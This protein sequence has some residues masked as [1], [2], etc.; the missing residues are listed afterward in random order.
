MPRASW[1]L[2]L[3]MELLVKN[4]IIIAAV[5][6]GAVASGVAH[7]DTTGLKLILNGKDITPLASNNPGVACNRYQDGSTLIQASDTASTVGTVKIGGDNKLIMLGMVDGSDTYGMNSDP[8]TPGSYP[9]GDDATVT[10]TASAS[11][12]QPGSN[13][14]QITGHAS[15]M[16]MQAGQMVPTGTPVPFEFDATCPPGLHW[17]PIQGK[18]VQ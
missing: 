5:L 8:Q 13:L 16:T 2:P 3:V 12:P 15:R 18:Y 9:G 4:L 11:A 10:K 1:Y 14:Y 17:D 7:A 6:A